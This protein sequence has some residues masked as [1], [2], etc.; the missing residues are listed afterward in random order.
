MSSFNR[1]SEIVRYLQEKQ[2]A[3]TRALSERFDVSEVTIRQDLNK[4]EESGW[5]NRVH[6][7][8][9]LAPHLQ[10][11]Q[12]FSVRQKLHLAEKASIARAA[13][14]TIQSGDTILLDGSTTAYQLALHLH[15]TRD[16]R[17]VTNNLYAASV[18]A[19]H[20]AIELVLLGGVVRGETA[21]VVGPPAEEMLAGVH[22]DKGFFGAAGLVPERGLTDADIR[23]VQIKR[24]MIKAVDW[25]NVL[26]DASKFGV[27]AFLPFA[28]LQEIH[29]LFTDDKI[30]TAYVELCREH[31]IDLV[32]V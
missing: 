14:E 21:T 26:L 19:T 29:R 20:R 25:V 3:S 10:G 1:R 18:L 2:R 5:L 17:V 31:E 9:E 11:E 16:V 32:V 15:K 12:P 6:G 8:A 22:A 30:P 4:L 13:A 28:T 27:Q 23:E 7:G 24:A